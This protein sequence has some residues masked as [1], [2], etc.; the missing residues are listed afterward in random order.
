MLFVFI[1]QKYPIQGLKIQLQLVIFGTIFLF[2]PIQWSV[3]MYSP[4]V[5]ISM[6][7]AQMYRYIM[8]PTPP[9]CCEIKQ[10]PPVCPNTPSSACVSRGVCVVYW[11][12]LAILDTTMVLLW[13]QWEDGGLG[14]RVGRWRG[15]GSVQMTLCF[16]IM[17]I[18][19]FRCLSNQ[20]VIYRVIQKE[21]Q[22]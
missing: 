12:G 5:M 22:Q 17:F 16:F 21:C 7:T 11:G 6:T 18:R 4:Y 10:I 14:T 3:R 8:V 19:W 20:Y 1:C 13:V 2:T 15:G 9:V